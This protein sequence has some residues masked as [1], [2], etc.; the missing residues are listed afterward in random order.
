MIPRCRTSA[1]TLFHLLRLFVM[2]LGE[3]TMMRTSL[4]AL[5]LVQAIACGKTQPPPTPAAPSVSQDPEPAP[6]P[7]ASAKPEIRYY[8]FKG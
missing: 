8:A 1:F 6:K 7:E 4:C 5:L 3:A 2:S